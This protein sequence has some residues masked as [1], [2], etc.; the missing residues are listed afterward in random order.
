ME[1]SF[2]PK[3]PQ[4][5]RGD[6][7]KIFYRSSWEFTC[8]MKFDLNSNVIE[9][10]SEEIQIPYRTILDEEYEIR[11]KLSKKRYHRYFVDFYVKVK[12]RNGKI[13]RYLIEVKP[14]N[15][16]VP[17]N[18]ADYSKRSEKRFIADRNRWIINEAKWK[19][20]REYAEDRGMKFLIHTEEEIYGKK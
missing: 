7:T 2:K 13:N 12:D 9:W 14:K 18:R 4:K 5:Y 15:Q 11:N 8:M 17:P 19:A 6:P 3:N 16:T 1:G 20:A 10:S